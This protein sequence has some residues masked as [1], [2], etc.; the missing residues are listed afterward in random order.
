MGFGFG[1][2]LAGL[3]VVEAVCL[4]APAVRGRSDLRGEIAHGAVLLHAHAERLLVP[5]LAVPP[6][7]GHLRGLEEVVEQDDRRVGRDLLGLQL[8]VRVRVR[9]RAWIR[10]RVRVRVS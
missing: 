10:V 9:V 3:R 2:G 7:G 5:T 6:E 1:L 8:L 4:V